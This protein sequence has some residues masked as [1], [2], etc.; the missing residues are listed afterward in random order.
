MR[1]ECSRH[2][3]QEVQKQGVGI[4]L[5]RVPNQRVSEG[6]VGECHQKGL[7]DRATDG[8]VRTRQDVHS[9]RRR[10]FRRVLH[11]RVTCSNLHLNNAGNAHTQS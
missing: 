6:P 9:E 8:L 1:A 2:K 3:E 4:V 11:R 7:G 5:G 10:K